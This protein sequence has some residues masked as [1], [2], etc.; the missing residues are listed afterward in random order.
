MCGVPALHLK[1]V[2]GCEHEQG[3]TQ[4][5]Q[6][7]LPKAQIGK[8]QSGQYTHQ[9]EQ[10]PYRDQ[11]QQRKPNQANASKGPRQPEHG[12]LEGCIEPC[13]GDQ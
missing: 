11:R 3:G 5:S 2:E 7:P 8:W 10:V 13:H 12:A 4:W 6:P 9:N 1:D